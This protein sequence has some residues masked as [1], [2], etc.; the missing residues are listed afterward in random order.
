MNRLERSH[1]EVDDVRDHL[2][3]RRDDTRA[4]ARAGHRAH[5]PVRVEHQRGRHG[6]EHALVRGD[7]VR[8][9]LNQAVEIGHARLARKI[10]HLDRDRSIG[11][12]AARVQHV[13][14]HGGS[15]R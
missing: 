2:P 9:A 6:R 7:G 10:V 15:E 13:H 4:A 14:S 8:L 5:L 1:P 3:G 11:R 12:V